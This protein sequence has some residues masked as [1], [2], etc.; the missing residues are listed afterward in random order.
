[1]LMSRETAPESDNDSLFGDEEGTTSVQPAGALTPAR[2]RIPPNVKVEGLYFD[3]DVCLPE[4]VA[5]DLLE[6][7]KEK[8][9]FRGGTVN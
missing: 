7:I 1:M 8:D 6:N 2:R 9:Y 5:L 4:S 3:P